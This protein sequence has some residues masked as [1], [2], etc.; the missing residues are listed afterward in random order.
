MLFQKR[1]RNVHFCVEMDKMVSVCLLE[2]CLRVA[3]D[4]EWGVGSG[5]RG[6]GS[7]VQGA[8]CRERGAGSRE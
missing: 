7:K 6:A 1:V 8:K 3:V 4:R 2:G 5:E